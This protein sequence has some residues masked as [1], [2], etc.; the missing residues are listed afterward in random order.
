LTPPPPNFR[1]P[2][3]Y[4]GSDPAAGIR[5]HSLLKPSAEK[6][7]PSVNEKASDD[8]SIREAKAV[9]RKVRPLDPSGEQWIG[10]HGTTLAGAMG[11]I[12]SGPQSPFFVTPNL[13]EALAYAGK[14]GVVLVVCGAKV[15]P[16]FGEHVDR[17]EEF[18]K[19]YFTG[20]GIRACGVR[21]CAVFPATE[22]DRIP[23]E[24]RKALVEENNRKV[25]SEAKFTLYF[26]GIATVLGV[27][28]AY[29]ERMKLWVR[30]LA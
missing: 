15:K 25:G 26:F 6:K 22:I 23:P 7:E 10:A 5:P 27:V 16:R 4:H 9:F 11:I 3:V 2:A 28:T 30:S 13:S 18:G 24:I 20:P 14:D 19:I 29:F 8:Q 12:E 1:A 21:I 17:N